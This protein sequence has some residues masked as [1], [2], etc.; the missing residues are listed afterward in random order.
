MNCWHC[1]RSIEVTERVGFRDYCPGCER[2]LHCCRNC[3]FY[4]PSFNN[5]CRETMAERVV[6]KGRANFCE[7]F[8]PM[9][10][11]KAGAS[12]PIPEESARQ[13]LEALFKKKS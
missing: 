7:Y 11:V 1:A 13:K 2:A 5:Q 3:N 8:A 9:V 4:D 6:D 12:K 10:Q